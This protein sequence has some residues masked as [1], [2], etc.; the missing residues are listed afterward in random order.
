MTAT[1]RA[2]GALLTLALGSTA[3]AA[4]AARSRARPPRKA[5]PP[6]GSI[7]PTPPGPPIPLRAAKLHEHAPGAGTVTFVAARRA[8]LDAGAQDGLAPGQSIALA[9]RGR[10][11]GACTVQAVADRS[12]TCSGD[13]VLAGDTFALPAPPASTVPAVTPLPPLLPAA[14]VDRRRAALESGPVAMIE[15][16]P[17]PR[18]AGA[19]GPYRIEASFVHA[20]FLAA[21]AGALH[22]ERLE[23]RIQGAEALPG[24]RLFLDAGAVYRTGAPSGRFRPGDS[25]YLEVRELQL[26]S[27]EPDRALAVALGRVLPWSAPGSTVFDGVQ[28]GWRGSPGEVGIFGGAVPDPLTTGL[29]TSRAT[30][31]AYGAVE[32]SGAGSLV[33]GEGR[34]AVVRSPELGTRLEAEALLHAWLARAVDLSGQARFGFGGDHTAP[35]SV[36]AARLDVSARLAAPVWLTGSVR[37]VGLLVA[38][39]AAPA[40]FPSPARHADLTASWDVAPTVTLRATGGYARDLGSG[41]DRGYGGPEI[42]LPRLFGHRGGLS[43]GWLE[44]TGWAGG[45]SLWLQ[46]QGEPLLGL[47]LL[48]RGSLFMDSRPAP[49][50]PTSTVGVAAGA[51]QDLLPWLRLRVSALG[52]VDLSQSAGGSL[53]GLSVLAALDGNI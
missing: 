29:T 37:Y 14:E 26:A 50:S 23:A 36:D 9:R 15:Y 7:A 17:Q 21:G 33:R 4:P 2:L 6:L 48:L 28:L 22:Q 49:L 16:T 32:R 39:P 25:A 46:G 35:A 8:Y 3:M 53:G 43:A 5:P 18:Y 31:G 34:F 52:R 42:A 30:A 24:W 27:R 40:L 47:R 13:G 10:P 12:A 1:S 38:D 44:E 51:S 20:S 45:R 19:G 41:L 11:A